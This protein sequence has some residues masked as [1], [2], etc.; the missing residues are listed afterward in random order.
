MSTTTW[1][2]LHSKILWREQCNEAT[3]IDASLSHAA[4]S[5]KFHFC[6]K[7]MKLHIFLYLYISEGGK[8]ARLTS[9][10]LIALKV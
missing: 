4:T 2:Y 9:S 5:A 7:I 1:N 8:L 6:F 3:I 10:A